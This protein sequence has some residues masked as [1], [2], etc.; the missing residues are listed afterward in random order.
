MKI[1]L[2][3]FMGVGKTTIGQQLATQMDEPFIDLD[4]RIA[5]HIGQTTAEFFNHAGEARFRA[6]EFTLLAEVLDQDAFILST[7]GGVLEQ[8]ESQA[9]IQ[10]SDAHVIWLDSTFAN[11]VSRLLGTDAA[12][13][14]LLLNNNIVALE[15]LWHHRQTAFAAVANEHIVTDFKTP[16]Q[17]SAEITTKIQQ[18]SVLAFERSQIDALD[19]EILQALTA[20]MAVV[21]RIGEIKAQHKLPIVQNGRMTTAKADIMT[22][23]GPTLPAKLIT[24]YLQLVTRTAIEHQQNMPQFG[25]R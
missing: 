9:L 1:I 16:A 13:R 24:E 10:N 17:I 21:N 2:V 25:M 19:N 23:F 12:D 20:R 3:G 15:A 11:N 18:D 6:V 7:G 8:A 5:E 4:A 14:P 22:R